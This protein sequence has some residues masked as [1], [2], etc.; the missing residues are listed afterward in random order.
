MNAYFANENKTITF[1]VR[2]KNL[3]SIYSILKQYIMPA[4]G[5]TRQY[6]VHPPWTKIKIEANLCTTDHPKHKTP[7]DLH[8]AK[9]Y[10]ELLEKY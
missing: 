7:P 8:R 6:N 10:R 9:C 5:T 2:I 4:T 3:F 1:S